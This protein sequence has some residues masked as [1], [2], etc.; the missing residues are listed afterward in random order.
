MRIEFRPAT[1]AF[2]VTDRSN[3][4]TPDADVT[5]EGCRSGT[6]NDFSVPDEEII[7]V[8]IITSADK[9]ENGQKNF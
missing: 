1:C 5:G 2:Q 4:V 9:K 6:V 3:G 7:P 8:R